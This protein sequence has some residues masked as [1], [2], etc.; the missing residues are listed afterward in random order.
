MRR[1]HIKI[2]TRMTLYNTTASF[3]L[4][5][6]AFATIYLLTAHT[7]MAYLRKSLELA[8]AQVVVQVENRNGLPYYEDEVPLAEDARYSVWLA[9]GALLSTSG[10]DLPELSDAA[11][12]T[13]VH[14]RIENAEYLAMTSGSF[15]VGSEQVCAM[16]AVSCE[17]AQ[18][19]LMMLRLI[20]IAALPLLALFSVAINFAVAGKIL[21]PI[22][23]IT[24]T[25]DKLASG[26][27]FSLR[28]PE[29]GMHDELDDLIHTLNRMLET[30]DEAFRRERR[31]T[32]DA[33]HE[34]RTPLAVITSY[35]ENLLAYSALSEEQRDSLQTILTECRRM[36]RLIGQML[37][38]AR[39]QTGSLS[40][41][42]ETLFLQDTIDGIRS[43][44][45]E[46]LAKRNIV[47]HNDIPA[48]FT[49]IADQSLFT[50]L[51]L[52]LIENAI[53]YGKDGGNI[54]VSAKSLS[55]KK[56]IMVSDDGIGI[57]ETDLPHIFERF[58]RVDA[59]RDRSG[60]GLGLSVAQEIVHLH[61]GT[62]QASS[63][64]GKG[65][66]FVITLEH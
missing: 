4:F 26:G 15:T 1:P 54:T 41:H 59:V 47:L 38:I 3:L 12:Y 63:T 31:F 40:V 51:L 39:A 18:R 28:M 64:L 43:A 5:A 16:A 62:L 35:T 6:A 14:I 13:P 53:K 25:A 11:P 17:S 48:D 29:S 36:N 27:D 33:S 46:Q 49:L 65:T 42:P 30:L 44:L 58:Y 7:L 66:C 60:T 8:L 55:N 56:Q 23:S 37:S 20:L 50:Q 61:N 32:S 9:D 45:S 2:R 24:Q 22:H 57:S 19:V 52:N 10:G 21:A 34:L